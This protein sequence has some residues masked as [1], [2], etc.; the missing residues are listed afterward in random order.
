MSLQG[1]LRQ[2]GLADVLQTALAGRRGNLI[3]RRGAMRA[4]LHIAAD[5]LYL[6]EPDPIDPAILLEGFVHRGLIPQ[7]TVAQAG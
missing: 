1:S 7:E 6:V 4:V 3:L 2:L 5:E